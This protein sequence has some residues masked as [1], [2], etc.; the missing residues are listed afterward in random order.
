MADAGAVR[1]RCGSLRECRGSC[2]EESA[3]PA[4][5]AAM[6]L[7]ACANPDSRMPAVPRAS[8][9]K[10]DRRQRR[11][12]GSRARRTGIPGWIIV[13]A[14]RRRCVRNGRRRASAVC[15]TARAFACAARSDQVFGTDLPGSCR[16]E[17]LCRQD[18]RTIGDGAEP[19]TSAPWAGSCYIDAAGRPG[20][21]P[22]R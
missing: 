12:R 1:L 15:R 14:R 6:F 3:L 7:A 18:A 8:I 16:S 17:R 20:N 5:A 22:R 13:P 19:R 21:R 2:L 4:S 10:I 11:V 9:A